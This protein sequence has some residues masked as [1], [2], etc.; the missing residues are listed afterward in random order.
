[1]YIVFEI[2][3]NK[4]GTVGVIP[5]KYESKEEAIQK[6]YQILSFAVVS[7]VPKHSAMIITDDAMVFKSECYIHEEQEVVENEELSEIE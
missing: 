1:M 3:A 7:D 5:T 6:Y 2:Q 4:D